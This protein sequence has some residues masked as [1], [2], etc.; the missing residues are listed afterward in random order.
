VPA[1]G[2]TTA[3][4]LT[5]SDMGPNQIAQNTPFTP[6]SAL[7][8]WSPGNITDDCSDPTSAPNYAT[9]KSATGWV[10]FSHNG[11]TQGG[12]GCQNGGSGFDHYFLYTTGGTPE[13]REI[14]AEWKL[15]G[16][17][18][19]IV[20]TTDYSSCPATGFSGQALSEV[21]AAANLAANTT[22]FIIFSPWEAAGGNN[23]VRLRIQ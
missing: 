15:D 1:T 10:Y 16:D 18:D 19:L 20:C 13:T 5:L 11:G 9:A 4:T 22:Y 2:A 23:S 8:V 21:I 7:D 3:A 17:M 12:T 6:T 14:R